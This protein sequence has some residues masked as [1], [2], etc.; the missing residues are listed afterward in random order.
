M[1]G[2][3]P[4]GPQLIRPATEPSTAKIVF[5]WQNVV[6][7]SFARRAELR[8]QKWLI[9]RVELELVASRNFLLPR[10]DAVAL[11]RFRGLGDELISSPGPTGFES[12]YQN[13]TTGD[14]QEWDI[15]LQFNMPIGFRREYTA[16]RNAELRLAR[17]RALLEGTGVPHHA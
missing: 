7:E 11:Y 1:L 5:P 2:L 16:L 3:P 8:R 12:A 17:E 15:G 14:Y 9:K 10:L 4:N 6:N 13:L